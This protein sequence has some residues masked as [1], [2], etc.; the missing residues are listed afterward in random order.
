MVSTRSPKKRG[1]WK[2]TEEILLGKITYLEADGRNLLFGDDGIV[3]NNISQGTTLHVLHDNPQLGEVVPQE[4]VEEVDNVGVSAVLHDHDLVDD[5][6]LAGLVSKIHLLDRDLSLVAKLPQEVTSDARG[7]GLLDL[8][9]VD[10]AGGALADLL[11]LRVREVGVLLGYGFL[12]LRHHLVL[13]HG[14]HANILLAF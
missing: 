5:E 7:G 9:D 11:L 14:R 4:G 13:G 6:L 12:Q 10:G 8:C 1:G 2:R 3:V